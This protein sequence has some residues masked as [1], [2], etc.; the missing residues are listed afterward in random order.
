MRTN[1]EDAFAK[2]IDKEQGYVN[3]PEDPGGVTN[4]G[5]TIKV[6]AAWK[7]RD[8]TD[9]EMRSLTP[10]MVAPLYKAQYWN[11][12]RCDDLPS[13]V[14][15]CVF[16]CAVNSG[17]KRAI[18]ILQRCVN[19]EE[20]GLIG[21]NTLAAVTSLDP[22]EIIDRFCAERQSYLESLPTFSTFGKGWIR[23]VAE[24]KAEAMNLA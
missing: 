22:S 4:L 23:R 6:W 16:D 11:Q 20:D 15:I 14:D 2:L 9:A 10:E 21:R 7:G 3:H 5:V 13:G 18:K 17:V 24:I 19:V 8:V 12:C 1:F